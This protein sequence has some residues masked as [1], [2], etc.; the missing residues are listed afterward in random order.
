MVGQISELPLATGI[1]TLF[2][3]PTERTPSRGS[4]SKGERK[5]AID[6]W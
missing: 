5:F 6:T 3:A 1:D 4:A 2:T